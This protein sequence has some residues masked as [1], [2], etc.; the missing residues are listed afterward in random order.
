MMPCEGRETPARLLVVDDEAD[1]V[2]YLCTALEDH[3]FD[4]AGASD[5]ARVPA[6]VRQKRPDAILLDILMPGQSGL[7]L[8]RAL[9]QDPGTRDI[10]VIIVTG[11]S[12]P[13]ALP[14][15]AGSLPP[16]DGYLEKPIAVPRLVEIVRSVLRGHGGTHRA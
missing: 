2:E 4:A 9:R 11:V 5:A 14:A 13:E 16:P 1:I 8:Y 7:A 3:G 10:P 15:E 12:R 6:L